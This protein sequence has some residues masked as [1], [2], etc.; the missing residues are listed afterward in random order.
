MN[1]SIDGPSFEEIE[2][3]VPFGHISGKYHNKF[4]RISISRKKTRFLK[5]IY[6]ITLI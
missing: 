5:L 6:F 2:I 4:E 3:P 1:K